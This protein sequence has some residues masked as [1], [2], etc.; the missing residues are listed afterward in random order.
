MEEKDL[1]CHN[2]CVNEEEKS[3]V[4]RVNPKIYK[5]HIIMRAAE[6]LMEDSHIVVDGDPETS[7][8]VK[9]ISK[10][11]DIT[12]DELL[13]IAYKFNTSLVAMSGKA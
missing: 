12:R 7:I 13:Q 8:V 11:K 1:N 10:K 5:V 6:E 2:I 4:V 3:V 9:F